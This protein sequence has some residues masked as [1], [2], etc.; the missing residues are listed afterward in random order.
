M[1]FVSND[2]NKAVQSITNELK[3]KALNW[4]NMQFYPLNLQLI[5]S[6]LLSIFQRRLSLL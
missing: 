6:T 3:Q 2:K 4:Y 5:N 1:Y